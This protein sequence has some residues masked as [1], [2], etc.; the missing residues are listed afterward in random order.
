MDK[1][2]ISDCTH[3]LKV[4]FEKKKVKVSEVKEVLYRLIDYID[5]KFGEDQRDT[6]FKNGNGNAY[7]DIRP[8][9][10]IRLEVS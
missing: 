3:D 9:K 6:P 1:E 10:G 2:K 5:V 4:F 8:M 7:K